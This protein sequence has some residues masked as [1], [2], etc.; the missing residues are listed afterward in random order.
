MVE[1]DTELAGLLQ[2]QAAE[3][4]E[5]RDNMDGVGGTLFGVST[6]LRRPLGLDYRRFTK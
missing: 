5:L 6:R 3:V 1:L 2:T 4:E